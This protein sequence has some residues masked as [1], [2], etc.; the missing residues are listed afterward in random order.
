MKDGVELAT[1]VYIPEG[2]GP[3]PTI[4]C[5][6]PYGKRFMLLLPVLGKMF[7]QRGYVFVA[8]D[9]RGRFDSEGDFFPFIHDAEDGYET[10]RWIQGQEWCNGMI[11][12]WG[13]SYFG[14]T[15]WAIAPLVPEL[16]AMCPSVTSPDVVEFIFRGGVLT[17][18]T[19]HNFAD[20]SR[21]RRNTYI[22]P[23]ERLEAVET[24]PLENVDDAAHADLEYFNTIACP[25]QARQLLPQVDFKDKYQEVSAP[26]LMVAGWYDMF[27][28]PQLKDFNRLRK[29]G[30]GN[31]KQS[32]LIIGPWAHFQMGGDKSVKIPEKWDVFQ[33]P[34]NL[35]W[36]DYWLRQEEN[37]V[38]D[39]PAVRY[40]LMGADEWKTADEWPP[41]GF[42]PRTY[43]LHSEGRANTAAGD[44]SLSLEPPGEEIPDYFEYNPMNPVPTR[45]GSSL[46]IPIMSSYP[47]P[48]LL[49]GPVDQA[50]VEGRD[51]VLVYSTPPLEEPVE[52]SGPIILYLY[53]SSSARDTDFT[54]KFLD[55]H[56]DGKAVLLQDGAIRARYRKG[57][58]EGESFIEPGKVYKYKIDLWQ[59][60]NYF[61]EGHQIRVEVSS[62]NFPRFARNLNTGGDLAREK[63]P[64]VAYQRIYHDA[65]HPSRLMITVKGEA[66]VE[67]PEEVKPEVVMPEEA[68][69]ERPEAGGDKPE[70]IKPAEGVEKD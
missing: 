7:A 28:G 25:E 21:D 70:I 46:V 5:R 54:A 24:L 60:A 48:N 30:K 33:L 27:L 22:G 3:A 40:F 13:I 69:E 8:Q 49:V 43:Y 4:L 23:L 19:A 41:P 44:G 36:Y 67:E 53:A 39:W 45:G 11:G 17:L 32:R 51:D 57:V 9:V 14:Y 61:P 38:E 68:E 42:G 26:A 59:T 35:E 56:P 62:S 34:A 58:D 16:K 50:P 6:L 2:I 12:T 65:E 10:F 37:G 66:P 63:T 47:T 31:A 64:I 20:F 1:D 18:L 15:Q 55:V 52:V 29:E